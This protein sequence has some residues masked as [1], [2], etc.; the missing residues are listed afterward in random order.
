MPFKRSSKRHRFSSEVLPLDQLYTLPAIASLS[1]LR[2][3]VKSYCQAEQRRNRSLGV[4][5]ITRHKIDAGHALAERL[6]VSKVIA[7]C[8]GVFDTVVARIRA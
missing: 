4:G 6:H 7:V 5:Q 2:A 3:S 1:E 8:K